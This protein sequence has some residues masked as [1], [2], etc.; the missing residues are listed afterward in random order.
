M[1]RFLVKKNAVITA[2]V[3]TAVA[4]TLIAA[5]GA[6]ADGSVVA[7]AHQVHG[8][9]VRFTIDYNVYD[10]Y[11]PLCGSV[12]QW[13]N[14][15]NPD[16]NNYDSNSAKVNVRLTAMRMVDCDHTATKGFPYHSPVRCKAV[17]RGLL[18]VGNGTLSPVEGTGGVAHWT[19]HK[20]PPFAY[21]TCRRAW[22]GVS[23]T[24]T[25]RV[26]AKV[27]DPV[28]WNQV[29]TKVQTFQLK[30]TCH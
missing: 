15:T 7:I 5:G 28:A 26:T 6:L 1:K 21:T 22:G 10:S 9:D 11:P 18:P 16:C 17:R 27:Y 12:D 25:W 8:K 4:A 2:L 30:R 14:Y 20:V 29:Y 13:G 24:V 23:V 19:D 3:A